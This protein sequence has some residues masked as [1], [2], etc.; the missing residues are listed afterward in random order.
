MFNEGLK[1]PDGVYGLHDLHVV[2]D[3]MEPVA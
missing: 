1:K 3:K 2:C